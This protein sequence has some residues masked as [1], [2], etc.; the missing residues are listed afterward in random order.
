MVEPGTRFGRLVVL[1]DEG[2]LRVRCQCDC[3]KEWV[4]PRGRLVSGTTRSCGCLKSELLR[5]KWKVHS[6][7]VGPPEGQVFGRLT[8][9]R[10]ERQWAYCLCTC[11]SQK[12]VWKYDLLSGKT[13][14]CGCLNSEVAAESLRKTATVH[15]GWGTS[16]W[17]SWHSMLDRCLD[18]SAM[19]YENYGGRGINVCPSWCGRTGFQAFLNDVGP[20]PSPAHTIDR[21]DNNRGYEPGNVRWAT[22]KEQA[23]NRRNTRW[24]TAFGRK[25]CLSAWA[26][27]TGL[28]P[29]TISYRLLKGWPPEKALQRR[30]GDNPA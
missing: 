26:E 8:V 23:R 24:I 1:V 7:R 17:N 11:G 27:E 22:R 18:P 19:G 20:A 25:Q 4:L 15:G 14:S 5:Q 13:S 21:I 10:T 2:S 12:R 3:G 9:V 16:E 28:S 6:E 29:T 30:F